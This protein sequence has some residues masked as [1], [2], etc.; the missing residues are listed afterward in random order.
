M[1]EKGTTVNASYRREKAEKMGILFN[2]GR[3]RKDY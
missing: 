1:S 3:G 2:S